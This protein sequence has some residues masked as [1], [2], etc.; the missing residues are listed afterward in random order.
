VEVLNRLKFG[1]LVD[2]NAYIAAE[3]RSTA[4]YLEAV[5]IN[6][7]NRAL[8]RNADPALIYVTDDVPMLV[9]DGEGASHIGRDVD[10]KAV[11]GVGVLTEPRLRR[12]V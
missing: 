2:G 9:D 6:K 1:R 12:R 5:A 11:V 10:E 7:C 3:N 4:A 8:V